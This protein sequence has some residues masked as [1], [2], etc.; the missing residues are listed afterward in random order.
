MYFSIILLEHA[1]FWFVSPWWDHDRGAYSPPP[2]PTS[3]VPTLW[4][5]QSVPKIFVGTTV[6]T[7]LWEQST[8]YNSTPCNRMPNNVQVN[9]G[10]MATSLPFTLPEVVDASPSLKQTNHT[11]LYSAQPPPFSWDR[12]MDKVGVHWG[13]DVIFG[14]LLF[15]VDRDDV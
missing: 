3:M 13:Y 8:F 10:W 7:H 6:P 14:C 12:T 11:Y 5:H 15:V 1:F 9:V 4:E 2:S